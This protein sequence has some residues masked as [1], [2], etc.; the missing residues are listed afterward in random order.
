MDHSQ[1][2]ERTIGTFS[3]WNGP[4]VG[5]RVSDG[6]SIFH[7]ECLALQKALDTMLEA[8]SGAFVIFSDSKSVLSDL[9]KRDK[10]SLFQSLFIYRKRFRK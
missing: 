3:E 1:K 9:I 8:G 5:I 10:E 4:S 2:M 7:G 6:T